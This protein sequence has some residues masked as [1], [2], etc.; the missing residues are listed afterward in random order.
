MG[1]FMLIVPPAKYRRQR[2]R[3]KERQPM[4]PVPLVLV[5]ASYDSGGGFVVL[6]FE[7][8]IDVSGLNGSLVQLND[9]ASDLLFAGTNGTVMLDASTVQIGLSMIEDADEPGVV[10]NVLAGNGI[11][12]V[13]DG[14]AW[15]GVSELGL[16]FP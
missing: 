7:R 9:P 5:S 10:L 15:A 12:V 11:V 1:F 8:P 14:T 16:P 13:D 2:G 3:V 4:G 6:Q